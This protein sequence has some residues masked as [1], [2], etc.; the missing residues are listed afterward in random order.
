MANLKEKM[1]GIGCDVFIEILY[2]ELK[3]N[4]KVDVEYLGLRY[5]KYSKYTLKSQKNTSI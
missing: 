1:R 3:R 5:E 2:P 4:I